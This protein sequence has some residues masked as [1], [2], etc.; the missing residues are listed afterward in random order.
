MSE[1]LGYT[2]SFAAGVACG[3]FFFGG[4]WW[5]VRAVVSSKRAPLWFCASL[6]VRTAVVLGVFYVA[7]AL[8]WERLLACLLGFV[9]ARALAAWLTRRSDRRPT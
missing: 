9:S 5:T 7:S 6:L 3:A 8:R 4:L 2:V 1:M